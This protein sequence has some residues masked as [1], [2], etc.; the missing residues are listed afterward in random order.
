M[1]VS[2]HFDFLCDWKSFVVSGRVNHRR[3]NVVTGQVLVP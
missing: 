2:S 1:I 3:V